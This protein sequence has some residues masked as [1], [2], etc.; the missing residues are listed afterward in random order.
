MKV[1]ID[2]DDDDDDISNGDD[3]HLQADRS[4]S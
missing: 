3:A 4:C 1:T 2:D